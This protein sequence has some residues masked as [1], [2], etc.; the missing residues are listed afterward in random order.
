MAKVCRTFTLSLCLQWRWVSPPSS[1]SI[2]CSECLL[3]FAESVD[4][5]VVAPTK[6]TVQQVQVGFKETTIDTA[7]LSLCLQE[8][9][10]RNDTYSIGELRKP[11]RATTAP[12]EL[13]GACLL[14]LPPEKEPCLE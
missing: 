6:L 3:T 12:M 2:A 8:Q 10:S 5:N 13:L 7:D 11:L 9:L 14:P 1:R 4:N